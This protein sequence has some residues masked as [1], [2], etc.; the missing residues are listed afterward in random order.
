LFAPDSGAAARAFHAS[1]VYSDVA[2]GSNNTFYASR[3]GG[4]DTFTYTD[5]SLD[6][7]TTAAL[8]SF[9]QPANSTA[10]AANPN[11]SQ[12][13]AS[14]DVNS[15]PTLPPTRYLRLDSFHV[16][17]PNDDASG[18]EPFINVN[19]ERIYT[20]PEDGA[21]AGATV[22]LTN[23]YNRVLTSDVTIV[24]QEEDVTQNV[25]VGAP[26]AVG[27]NTA[28]GTYQVTLTTANGFGVQFINYTFTYTV[29]DVSFPTPTITPVVA[30]DRFFNG[31]LFNAR[32]VDVPGV[33]SLADLQY[34]PDG[35][36]YYGASLANGWITQDGQLAVSNGQWQFVTTTATTRRDDVQT[37]FS[38]DGR[39]AY[40]ISTK[41]GVLTVADV[42]AVTRAL[43][44]AN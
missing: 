22:D 23:Y 8:P 14:F 17:N 10:V 9:I 42:D 30:F 11:G 18:D 35:Q 21:G 4:V 24:V 5:F 31:A 12:V 13:V 34:S 15:V 3:V 26:F 2:V 38:P 40:S 25:P 1:G 41:F 39:H 16:N 6:L 7:V 29:Y 33:N 36:H 27:T 19:G 44:A 43:G 32:P 37:A 28:P 20:G